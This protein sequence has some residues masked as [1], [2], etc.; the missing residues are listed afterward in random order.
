MYNKS[1]S[2][3]ST[4]TTRCT[5]QIKIQELVREE[6]KK[7]RREREKMRAREEVGGSPGRDSTLNDCIMPC[8]SQ[9]DVQG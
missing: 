4:H 5:R 9:L 3:L 6:G 2:L 8:F 1:I 7:G